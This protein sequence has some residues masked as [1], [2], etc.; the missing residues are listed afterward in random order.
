MFTSLINTYQS[1]FLT[2]YIT[3]ITNGTSSS[4][5]KRATTATTFTCTTLTNIGSPTIG[6]LSSTQLSTLSL[7][8]FYSCVTLLG[9]SANSWSSSQLASLVSLTK[10][11]TFLFYKNLL[12]FLLNSFV[13]F[14]V[15][16]IIK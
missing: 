15:L 16:F 12:V 11:V 8:D 7:S 5:K 2:N 3:I 10:S 4:R 14:I 1:I 9:Y 6:S 13:I